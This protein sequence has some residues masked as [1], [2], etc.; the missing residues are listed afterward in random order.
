MVR[1]FGKQDTPAPPMEPAAEA[2][3]PEP[4]YVEIPIDLSLIN[5]KLNLLF[6][7]LQEIEDLIKK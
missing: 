4:E 2:K 1:I 3:K 6:N 5:R 7:K